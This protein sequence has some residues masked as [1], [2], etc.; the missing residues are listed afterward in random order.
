M[1]AGAAIVAQAEARGV[2]ARMV[3]VLDCTG[4]AFRAW[5]RGGYETLVRRRPSAWGHLYRTSDRPLLNY[6]FQTA[7]DW[8]FCGP[9]R[10]L[11][12]TDRPD[13]VVCTHS[14]P[15]P[16]LPRLRARFGFKTAVVVTDLYPHRMWLRGAP[17]RYF[18]PTPWSGDRL[19]AR[20]GHARS[21]EVTGIPIH[22]AFAR[23]GAP[24]APGRV[25]LVTSGGIGAG[26]VTEAIDAILAA[27][28]SARFVAGQNDQ[29]RQRVAARYAGD[30][31]VA[32]Y[33]RLTP[34]QMAEAM[35]TSD[36]LVGKPGGLT[37]F[38]A[39]A[40]G[41][42]F[43]VYVPFI[44]PGQEE[45]NAEYLVEAGAGAIAA[46]PHGLRDWLDQASAE[47]LTAMRTAARAEARPDAAAHIVGALAGARSR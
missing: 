28:W 27:G 11:I 37:T 6:W 31:R 16:R 7:L 26:P 30:P 12:E 35:R 39:L 32:A 43:L 21:I 14:L 23:P 20:L 42:P 19:A 40:I 33:G 24:S 41:I 1:S 36:L 4:R 13:W 47:R 29:A 45:R 46:D 9:I 38:E 10:R 34:Q 25:A 3:D 17:D 15:Q 2:P 22:P 18:V 8:T 5:F 44:I